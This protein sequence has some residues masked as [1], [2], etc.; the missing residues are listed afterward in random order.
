MSN[1]SSVAEIEDDISISVDFI[2]VFEFDV[3]YD[4][5]GLCQ[6]GTKVKIQSNC[7]LTSQIH[8][9]VFSEIRSHVVCIQNVSTGVIGPAYVVSFLYLSC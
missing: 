4:G 1:V 7:S 5:D 9:I 3:S 6:R 2:E 8:V